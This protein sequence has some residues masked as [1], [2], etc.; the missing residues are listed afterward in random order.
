MKMGERSVSEQ[1]WKQR[2]RGMKE[3]RRMR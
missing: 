3:D 1:K 2:E